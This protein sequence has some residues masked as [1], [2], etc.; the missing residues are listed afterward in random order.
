MHVSGYGLRDLKG[1]GVFVGRRGRW[2]STQ[3]QTPN[4]IKTPDPFK[5][6]EFV[7]EEVSVAEGHKPFDVLSVGEMRQ[8]YYSPNEAPPRIV[9]DPERVPE[10]LRYLI[11]VAEKW[12]IADDMLRLDAVRKAP[13]DEIKELRRLVA[14]NDDLLD[15]W[16]AGPEANA[17]NFSSEYLA[18]THMRMAADGC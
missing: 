6:F 15:E 17:G 8:K 18:F 2:P 3:G 16:L 14:E 1:S 13:E 5:F 7:A 10:P 9:L 4:L 12:G 11:P